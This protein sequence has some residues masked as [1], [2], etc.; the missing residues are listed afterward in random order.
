MVKNIV[1]GTNCLIDDGNT[2][3]LVAQPPT[4]IF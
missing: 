2:G 1:D 4:V 3:L